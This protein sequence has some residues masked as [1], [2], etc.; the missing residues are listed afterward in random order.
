MYIWT[1]GIVDGNGWT[2]YIHIWIGQSFLIIF[3]HYTRRNSHTVW[4][5]ILSYFIHFVIISIKQVKYSGK[6]RPWNKNRK[7]IWICIAAIYFISFIKIFNCFFTFLKN[8]I[9]F[10]KLSVQSAFLFWKNCKPC[11]PQRT[12]NSRWIIV[13]S[14]TKQ[15]L[16]V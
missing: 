2:S 1:A 4:V 3:L 13:V 16:A 14:D 10:A 8:H 6:E 12:V 7:I 11:S 15:R 5:C 9:V